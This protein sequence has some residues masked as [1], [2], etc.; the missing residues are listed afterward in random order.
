MTVKLAHSGSS[1]LFVELL[2]YVVIVLLMNKHYH[3]RETL[4][5]VD[6]L[7]P[8]NIAHFGTK[9]MFVCLSL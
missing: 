1:L 2:F 9:Q 7:H 4:P 5:H 3:F 8:R 6:V